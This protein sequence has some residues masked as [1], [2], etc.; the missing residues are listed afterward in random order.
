M[1][2][3]RLEFIRKLKKERGFIETAMGN[4][5]DNCFG[6]NCVIQENVTI[7]VDGFGY[8]QNEEGEYE[9]FPHFS[10]VVIGDNVD[11]YSFTSIQR[12]TLTPTYIAD[13][14]KIAGHCRIGHSAMIGKNCLIGA[15]SI[16]CGSA[17]IGDN[18]RMG[19]YVRIAPHVKVGK[20]VKITSYS[21]VLHDVPDGSH[22][23]G[24]PAVEM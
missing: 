15:Y 19:E 17:V 7:G 8:E 21:N 5:T 20:N 10:N 11:V 12:G 1:G 6:A 13:G 3:E 4:I 18:V 2:K 16:V 14:T 22:M 24:N 23:R 9:K